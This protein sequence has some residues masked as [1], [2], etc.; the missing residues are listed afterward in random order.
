[1]AD[2]TRQNTIDVQPV[3]KSP[4]GSARTMS[5]VTHYG[6]AQQQKVLGRPSLTQSVVNL[7]QSKDD[8][9]KTN[10]ELEIPQLRSEIY[11]LQQ[12]KRRTNAEEAKLHELKAKLEEAEKEL[13]DMYFP[14]APQAEKVPP[15]R[16]PPPLVSSK[17]SASLH[18]PRR[19]SVAGDILSKWTKVLPAYRLWKTGQPNTPESTASSWRADS[20]SPLLSQSELA[21]KKREEHCGSDP[22]AIRAE[23]YRLRQK[24]SLTEV[25]ADLLASLTGK[26]HALTEEHHHHAHDPSHPDHPA[27]ASASP[28][29]HP[30]TPRTPPFTTEY[31]HYLQIDS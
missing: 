26:L 29:P 12:K 6:P 18:S 15:L 22:G 5:D 19:K 28:P 10:T 11:H 8:T 23:I 9:S 25:E 7:M 2:R 16:T 21:V 24:K 31:I 1:M 17:S 14:A 27:S 4:H 20:K 30:T 3:R 13:Q